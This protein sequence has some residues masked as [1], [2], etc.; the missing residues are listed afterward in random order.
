MN[1]LLDQN[2]KNEIPSFN[3]TDFIHDCFFILG[4]KLRIRLPKKVN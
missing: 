3:I 4:F 2:L 1:K